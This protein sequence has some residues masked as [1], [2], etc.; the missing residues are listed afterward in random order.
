MRILALL[1]ALVLVAGCGGG[2]DQPAFADLHPVTGVVKRD[3]QPVKGGQITFTMDADKQEFGVNSIVGADG[4]YTLTTYRKTDNTGER[5]NGAP[6]GSYK[7]SYVPD[8]GDQTAGGS[9]EPIRIP[10]PQVV[11]AGSNTL[12]IDLPARKK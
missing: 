4:T 12:H 7:V 9:M 11:V 3:G 6:A 10:N 8:I 2:K 5:K 1:G